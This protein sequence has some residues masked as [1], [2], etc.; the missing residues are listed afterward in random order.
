MVED[1]WW[2]VDEDAA[3]E[4]SEKQRVA[5]YRASEICGR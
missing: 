3:I 1:G 5:S 4:R 2:M